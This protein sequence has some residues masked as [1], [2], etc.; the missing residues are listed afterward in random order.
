MSI[1]HY[2]ERKRRE[3][4][5]AELVTLREEMSSVVSAI[6]KHEEPTALDNHDKGEC[7]MVD[8]TLYVTTRVIVRGERIVDGMNVT[9]TTL[10]DEIRNAVTSASK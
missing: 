6:A 4:Q 8:G 10:V 2:R 3:A 1:E 5:E 9:P 7:L